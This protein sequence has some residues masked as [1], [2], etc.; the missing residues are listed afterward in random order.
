ML[1]KSFAG[2]C[3]AMDLWDAIWARVCLCLFGEGAGFLPPVGQPAERGEAARVVARFVELTSIGA[4][5]E[6]FARQ[7]RRAA[8]AMVVDAMLHFGLTVAAAHEELEKMSGV[9]PPGAAGTASLR[10]HACAAL[11][12]PRM[13]L[14]LSFWRAQAI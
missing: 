6:R 3:L 11:N 8:A 13:H 9:P 7:Q 5:D 2:G 4:V 14:W 1:L 12:F 10:A